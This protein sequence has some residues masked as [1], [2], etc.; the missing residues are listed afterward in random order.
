L[1]S[2]PSSAAGVT[3]VERPAERG[4]RPDLSA[5]R[6]DPDELEYRPRRG[7]IGWLVALAAAG[8]LAA[9]AFLAPAPFLLP[10]VETT[11][12]QVVTPT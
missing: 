12:V 10:R 7:W 4:P 1:S 2:E 5:L 3:A 8:A 11:T 9:W 6:M